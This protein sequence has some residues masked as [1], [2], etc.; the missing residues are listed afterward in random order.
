[1]SPCQTKPA[2]QQS[3]CS[4][5]GSQADLPGQPFPTRGPLVRNLGNPLSEMLAKIPAAL[6]QRPAF[7]YVV[8]SV[9]VFPDEFVQTGCAPNYQGGLMSLCTCMHLHRSS[10]PPKGRRGPNPTDPWGGIWVAGLGST[11]GERPRAL[12]YLMLIGQTFNSPMACWN[13]LANPEA[14]SAFRDRFGDIYEPLSSAGSSPWSERSYKDHRA[15]HCHDP[16]HRRHDI[17]SN[18]YGRNARLLIGDP[19][20][21]FLWSAPQVTLT[22]PWKP[23][24]KFLPHLTQLLGILR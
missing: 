23:R 11:S 21:S 10:P 15:D 18:Y 20:L 7:V 19:N 24:F 2:P 16:A 5:P 9:N 12:F 4:P 13:G 1:M 22:K 8:D 14:K 6:Q 17:E 3:R